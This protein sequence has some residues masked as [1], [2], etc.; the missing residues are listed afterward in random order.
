[1]ARRCAPLKL[2]IAAFFSA[3]TKLWSPSIEGVG[4]QRSIHVGLVAML[5]VRNRILP[6]RFYL[7]C[8][9]DWFIPIHVYVLYVYIT[10]PIT[11]PLSL[12][13]YF[14]VGTIQPLPLDSLLP[15]D[16]H[17]QRPLCSLLCAHMHPRHRA[18]NWSPP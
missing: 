13:S 2:T 8:T 9:A 3:T 10:S 1:M 15:P 5:S 11:L 18:S 16:L 12:T 4:L 7:W 14:L 6:A 17:L